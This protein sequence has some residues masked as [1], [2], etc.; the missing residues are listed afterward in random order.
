ML[1]TLPRLTTAA[2]R[3]GTLPE[4]HC[5]RHTAGWKGSSDGVDELS[6]S[7]RHML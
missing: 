5:R 6:L 1:L 7:F 2:L 4:V 3:H